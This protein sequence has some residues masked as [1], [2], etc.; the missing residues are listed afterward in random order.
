MTG[1]ILFETEKPQVTLSQDLQFLGSPLEIEVQATDQKSGIQQIAI[2]LQQNEQEFQLFKK[3]FPRQAW[4]SKAGPGEIEET[5]TLD[6]QKA[7]GK[8]GDAKLTV[9]VHDFSLNGALQGNE[10][11]LVFPVK[12]DTKPPRVHIE[13]AQ[14]YITPGGS[15]IVVY[16]V[17]E[18]SERHGVMLDDTFFQGYPLRGSTKRFI[19]YIALPWNSDKPEQ[20]RVIAV[21][22]A[23]NE[24][25]TPFSMRFKSAK[26]KKDRINISDGFLNK[27]IPEFEDSY[28]QLNGTN[29]EKYLIVNRTVRVQN[30]EKIAVLCNNTE[31]EQ[32]WEGRFLRMAG[33]GRAGFADQRTYYYKGEPIDHQTHLGMD[34]ASTARVEV[35]AANNG[36]IIFADYLGIYGNMVMID[37]GQGLT[38]LYSHLSRI[39]VEVGQT[40]EKGEVI[41]N[42]GTTGMAG[43]DHLHF[44][45][46]VHGIFVTPIEWWDSHWI[47]VNINKIIE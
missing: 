37:H 45:M 19:A 38:S 30:A 43:G 36:K 24:G 47:D 28:P 21:D 8:E 4:L 31:S 16:S 12:I 17:S 29:L 46:L 32:L 22:Q 18:P 9:S 35:E 39:A 2:T 44:S 26:E 20:A 34:I 10:T 11:A 25:S 15:G 5:L 27:K 33:A 3:D 23:G 7:G 6:V 42:S 1:F 41:G 40:V 14:Q 13:H